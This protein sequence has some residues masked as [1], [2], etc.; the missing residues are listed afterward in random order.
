MVLAFQIY[1]ASE[2]TFAV[3]E[4]RVREG[5][6]GV[7]KYE[8]QIRMFVLGA[9]TYHFK[10]SPLTPVIFQARNVHLQKRKKNPNFF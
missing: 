6:V 9:Y 3:R 2:S 8:K 1:G 4:E 5:L 10:P 7:L